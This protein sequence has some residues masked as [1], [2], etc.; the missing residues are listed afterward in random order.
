M[1][2]ELLICTI[3][4][5]VHKLKGHLLVP[6]EGVSY[7]VSWQYSGNQPLVPEWLS[8]RND[9]RVVQLAGHGLSR[10]R[11]FALEHAKGDILKICDDDE[12]WTE[13]YF[14]DILTTYRQHPEYDIVQ[15]Q[16]IGLDKTYPPLYISSIE[17]TLRRSSLG[18]I[19]F[20]ERFGLGSNFLN[21]GEEEVFIHDA[22]KQGLHIHYEPRPICRTSGLTTGHSISDPRTLR[23]KGATLYYTRG[24]GYALYKSLRE[25]IGLAVRKHV[26][27]LTLFCHMLRG[28]Q[29]IHS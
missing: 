23:S 22:R 3:D 4:E 8:E 2:L 29:Y 17:L 5:G 26:N 19:R 10:N 24:M 7:L 6:H 14:D 28:I 1:T 27:P 21:A 18:S 20:N 13:A 16:A 25:S 15:F 9:V 12:Q 11:N